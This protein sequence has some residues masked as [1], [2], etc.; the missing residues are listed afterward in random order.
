M[1]KKEK[2]SIGNLGGGDGGGCQ[3]LVGG[4]GVDALVSQ[5]RKSNLEE[6]FK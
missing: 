5:D 1:S 4:L 3:D 6:K 2:S